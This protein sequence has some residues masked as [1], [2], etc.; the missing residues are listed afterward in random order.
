MI[1][2]T[3]LNCPFVSCINNCSSSSFHFNLEAKLCRLVRLLNET[4]KFTDK[5]YGRK[6]CTESAKCTKVIN[7]LL[8]KR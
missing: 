7:N 5:A 8:K 1:N 2:L 4:C 3:K 6:K